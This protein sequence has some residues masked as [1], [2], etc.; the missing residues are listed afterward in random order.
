MLSQLSKYQVRNAT[1]YNWLRFLN[2][3]VLLIYPHMAYKALLMHG[4]WGFVWFSIAQQQKILAL[5][6]HLTVC[7]SRVPFTR[8]LYTQA[9][10]VKLHF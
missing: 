5:A 4:R 8:L 10:K 3:F 6:K 1:V 2:M 9:G 7:G